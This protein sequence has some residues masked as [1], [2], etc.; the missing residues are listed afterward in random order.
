MITDLG[1][2]RTASQTAIIPTPSC[3]RARRATES[4]GSSATGQPSSQRAR[5]APPGRAARTAAPPADTA[6][7]AQQAAVQI[8]LA[9]SGSGRVTAR[10]ALHAA[11]TGVRLG[12][13]DRQFL[14]RLVAWD[15]RNAA[16]VASLI[17]RA[18][19]AGRDEAAL[20]SRQREVVLAALADAAVYRSSGG[21]ASSCWDCDNI[22]G[23]RC[24]D[25]VKD[26]D[27]ARA[28]TEVAAVLSGTVLTGPVL[29]SPVLS[30]P[31][32]ANPMPG[33]TILTSNGVASTVLPSRSPDGL[34]QPRG[35]AGYRRRTPVAS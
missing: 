34:S 30:S 4:S 10:S 20:T 15:K 8:S 7:P 14:T 26:N 23:G 28:Y 2:G 32:L 19:Q 25:H 27:R 11:L 17:G 9:G 3:I 1:N 33:G 13:R 35:R 18:R 16:S 24:A 29:S 21:A 31:V 12:A 5:T 22:P 6:Q